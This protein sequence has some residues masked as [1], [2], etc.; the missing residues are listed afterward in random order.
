MQ[1]IALALLL[2]ALPGYHAQLYFT[3]SSTLIP[4][5]SSQ[6]WTMPTNGDVDAME[7]VVDI[8]KPNED[9]GAFT[10]A[11]ACGDV[12]YGIWAVVFQ[13]V[14]VFGVNITTG[15]LIFKEE[16]EL[17]FQVLE[18]APGGFIGAATSVAGD[19]A[20]YMASYDAA[21]KNTNVISKFPSNLIFGSFDNA[22]VFS[23]DGTE[24][25]SALPQ[26]KGNPVLTIMSTSTGEITDQREFPSARDGSPY[27]V[28][29]G[30]VPGVTQGSAFVQNI[31]NEKILRWSNF[32]IPAGVTTDIS[33]S[34]G[35]DVSAYMFSSSQPLAL[36]GGDTAYSFFE[37]DTL[38]DDFFD[39]PVIGGISAFNKAT[40]VLLWKTSLPQLKNKKWGAL[41]CV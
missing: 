41:A 38:V 30:T 4:D 20:I 18:C 22:F 24:L 19:G 28:F 23:E 27:V 12:Y 8:P 2:S 35:A 17:H 3:A 40:G 36:C 39:V 32:T 31:N 1:R 14:G 9:L 7:L 15:S 37:S 6:V 34:S 25:W 10:G 11:V 26:E 21:T 29:P 16:T 5:S 33:I 13:A